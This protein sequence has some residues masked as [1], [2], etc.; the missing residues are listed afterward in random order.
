M[1]Y[2]AK[3]N[4]WIIW[5]IV[6]SELF[7]D[8]WFKDV[9]RKDVLFKNVWFKDVLFED[10]WFKDGLYKDVILLFMHYMC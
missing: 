4:W 5:L 3:C 9:L 7:E 10:V 2:L 6:V 8:V 1:N